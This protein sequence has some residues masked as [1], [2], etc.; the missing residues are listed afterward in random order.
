MDR[1]PFSSPDW[2]KTFHYAGQSQRYELG[3]TRMAVA[4]LIPVVLYFYSGWL[5]LVMTV[6]CVA[7]FCWYLETRGATLPER[8]TF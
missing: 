2:R 8:E 6:P 3:F 5:A 4:L 7:I 1:N